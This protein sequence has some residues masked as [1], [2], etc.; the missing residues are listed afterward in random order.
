MRL[1]GQGLPGEGKGLSANMLKS[2]AILAMLCDHV[3]WAFVPVAST[4]GVGMHIVGRITGPVMFFL[5]VEGYYH[6]KNVNRYIMR[7][8]IFAVVSWPLFFYFNYGKLPSV[9]SFSPVGVIYT[10]FIG[11]LMLHTLSQNTSKTVKG[12]AIIAT[13]LLSVIGDWAIYGIAYILVFYYFRGNAKRWFMAGCVIIVAS[14][15]PMLFSL[16]V[17]D[18]MTQLTAAQQAARKADLWA[19]AIIQLGQLLPLILLKFYNGRLGHGGR[20]SKWFFY[21]FYP[22]HLLVL[23]LLKY[24]VWA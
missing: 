1:Q 23:G 3:A 8:G 4:L 17:I 19:N 21:M 2:I 9:Y 7:M 18:G 16:P 14:F 12:I 10:L 6:T 24:I 11:L 22:A 20:V 5:L 13:F 15:L